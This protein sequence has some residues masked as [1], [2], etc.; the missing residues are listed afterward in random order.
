M[1]TISFQCVG[2][3]A[4]AFVFAYLGLSFFAYINKPWSFEFIAIE[5]LVIIVGRYTGTLGLVYLLG[6][7]G[8][9][10]M[11]SFNELVFIGYAGMIRGAIA[12]GLV[13]R[14]ALPDETD[15]TYEQMS[16]T[17]DVIVTS[18]ITL[19]ILTTIIYGSLMGL[20]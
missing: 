5:M 15:P 2:F 18:T 3:G 1:S 11:L 16:D 14:I 7:F 20:V 9:K 4:E 6:L 19:V 8:H 17:K 12:F 10:K 13:L